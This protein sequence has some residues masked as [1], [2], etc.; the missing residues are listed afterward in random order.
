MRSKLL[1]TCVL[2]GAVTVAAPLAAYSA[3]DRDADRSSPKAFVKDSM[4]TV[5]VKA[6]FAKDKEVSAMHIRVDTDDK[7]IVHLSGKARSQAE[8]D[9]AVSLARTTEGVKDVRS[10]IQIAAER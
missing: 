6:A 9:K 2:V 4:I 8:A 1:A 7:G 3:E 10:D 5:K